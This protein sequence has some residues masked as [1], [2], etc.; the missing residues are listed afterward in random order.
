MAAHQVV[1]ID[2]YRGGWVAVRHVGRSGAA[3]AATADSLDWA[4]APVD[5][6][7]DLLPDRCIAAID[8]PIGLLDSGE[9]ECDALARRRLPGATSRVFVTPPRAVLELGLQAPNDQVQRLCRALTGS[10]VSRQA[11]GLASRVLAL[12]HYLAGNADAVVVEAHPEISFCAM[13]AG[14]PLAS[15]KCAAGVGQRMAALRSWLPEV[16]AVVSRAPTEVPIDDALDALAC[17]WTAQRW[18]AGTA[19][20]LPERAQARPFIAI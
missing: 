14:P 4:T 15:K 9:R 7:G 16:D 5:A 10:G 12:D 18:A 1:G 2:G 11:L 17:L 20:T 19:A 8:M 6:I 3:D 13:T